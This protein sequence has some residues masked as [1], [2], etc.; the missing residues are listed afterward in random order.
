MI[1]NFIKENFEKLTN[2]TTFNFVK[3]TSK[4]I[5]SRNSLINV[6]TKQL[7]SNQTITK[8]KNNLHFMEE[9]LLGTYKVNLGTIIAG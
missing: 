5:S 1:K 9:I 7:T 2:E 6:S 8:F 3:S 4:K